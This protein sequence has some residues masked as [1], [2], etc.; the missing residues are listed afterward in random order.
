MRVICVEITVCP[1]GYCRAAPAPGQ[2]LAARTFAEVLIFPVLF[3]PGQPYICN[4]VFEHISDLAFRNTSA[5]IDL[6]GGKNGDV[7]VAAVAAA[8]NHAFLRIFRDLKCLGFIFIQRP[9][10]ILLIEISLAALRFIFLKLLVTHL[11]KLAI[12]HS[13]HGGIQ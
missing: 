12:F 5:G 9:E 3:H 6:A 7:A 8:L 4:S 1:A 11:K 2:K 13:G 10:M